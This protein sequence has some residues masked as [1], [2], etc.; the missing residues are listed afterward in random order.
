MLSRL[1]VGVVTR[2]LR[3]VASAGSIGAVS[4][5]RAGE[6]VCKGGVSQAEGGVY[7][8]DGEYL[9]GGELRSLSLVLLETP[10]YLSIK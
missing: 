5:W 8:A 9:I 10:S 2:D 7:K 1:E 4:W 3:G 6:I